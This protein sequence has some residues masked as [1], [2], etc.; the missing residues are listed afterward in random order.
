MYSESKIPQ[1]AGQIR[2]R[3]EPEI[4]RRGRTG[5]PHADAFQLITYLESLISP[6]SRPVRIEKPYTQKIPHQNIGVNYE[7]QSYGNACTIL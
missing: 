3:N 2:I 1:E 6:A 4:S 7:F 5:K